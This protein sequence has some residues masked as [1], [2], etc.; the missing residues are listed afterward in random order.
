MYK[1]IPLALLLVFYQDT[2]LAQTKLNQ[3]ISFGAA[4][5]I[6]F[7][8]TGKL[9][10]T[11][12]SGFTV[13]FSSAT[14]TVCRVKANKVTGIA[15]GICTI[16][17]NQPGNR[18]YLPAPP[19]SQTFNILKASQHLKFTAAPALSFGGQAKISAT[20]SSGLAVSFSSNT[21]DI[22]TLNANYLSSIHAGS[23]VIT[24]S[25]TG[26]AN[27]NPADS[28]TLTINIAK[29]A[30]TIRFGSAPKL[31]VGETTTLN[32]VAS[33]G[34]P[35]SLSTPSTDICSINAGIISAENPGV[36]K[37]IANQPGDANYKPAASHTLSITIKQA[38]ALVTKVANALLAGG[39][40]NDLKFDQ[41]GM[42]AL[43][44]WGLAAC[45]A[46]DSTCQAQSPQ[47]DRLVYHYR[48]AKGV[49]QDQTIGADINLTAYL[50]GWLNASA[51]LF[52]DSA[53]QAHVFV[54]GTVTNQLFHFV[55]TDGVW[56]L[57]ETID[58]TPAADSVVYMPMEID[59]QGYFHAAL[60]SGNQLYY[61]TNKTGTWQWQFVDNFNLIVNPL[62]PNQDKIE[63]D[64]QFADIPRFVSLA[65]D[66]AG[67]AHL[68][69]CPIFNQYTNANGSTRDQ[70]SLY[71]AT[72]AG[73]K[74]QPELVSKPLTNSDDAGYGGSVAIN[75][76]TQQAA[77][78]S[79]YV[80]RAAT[81]SAHS[82]ELLFH[83]QKNGH[84]QRS[85][86]TN[87]PDGY[88]AADGNI[89]AGFAPVL[90]F[91]A[92]GEAQIVFSDLA[93]QHFSGI[94]DEFAG[95]IRHARLSA[96]HKW[97]IETQF[98]QTNPVV[99]E[100]IYPAFALAPAQAVYAGIVKKDTLGKNYAIIKSDYSVVTVER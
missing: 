7:G 71:Y 50:N 16:D 80:S 76:L 22:C 44:Y 23:C 89:G 98:R 29:A 11:A 97:A 34:L 60:N 64:M 39:G 82:A 70:S 15:A 91:D 32:A 35:V 37:I 2:L 48:S 3:I 14:P 61:G 99:N 62:Y 53:N 1:F 45:A 78:S 66:K 9:S 19:L 65:V 86:V 8:H 31:L 42:P 6:S 38:T 85:V 69:Y 57:L 81:G 10:A 63:I 28:A 75:P 87:S 59:S 96:D 26:D 30:Q 79:F 17:A 56:S 72:N 5:Q 4:P 90:K 94:E 20:A 92:A 18:H 12:S 49:W 55:Q 51:S 83:T 33:S 100:I 21:P 13:R 68:V 52:F 74:W 41:Q 40:L 77:I 84:W 46:N 25:Q 43:L 27:Y 36:C 67:Y 58:N 73:G 47:I 93:T 95:Q 24:A 88:A 54:L